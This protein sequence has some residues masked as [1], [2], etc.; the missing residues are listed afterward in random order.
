MADPVIAGV[1][2]LFGLVFI[3]IIAALIIYFPA[4]SASIAIGITTSACV[5]YIMIKS[6]PRAMQI[7]LMGAAI[8]VSADGAYAGFTDQTPVTIANALVKLA[9]GIG[10]GVGLIATNAGS[11]IDSII[12]VGVWSFIGATVVFMGASFLIEHDG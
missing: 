3:G 1:P 7:S 5:C 10:Q 6:M 12:P 8:G 4:K 9:N 11:Q 2:I